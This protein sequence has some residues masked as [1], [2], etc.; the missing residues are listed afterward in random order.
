MLATQQGH[1]NPHPSALSTFQGHTVQRATRRTETGGEISFNPS[2]TKQSN[3]NQAQSNRES[4]VDHLWARMVE[5]NNARQA[6]TNADSSGSSQP[7]GA[8]LSDMLQTA[9][10]LSETSLKEEEEARAVKQTAVS[11]DRGQQDL[12][13]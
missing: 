3:Q 5:R 8:G 7:N 13:K 1:R 11:A 9:I 6:A 4:H 12:T 2:M 10:D